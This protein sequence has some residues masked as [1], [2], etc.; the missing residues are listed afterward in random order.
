[1]DIW[2]G[3]DEVMAFRASLRR[4]TDRGCALMTAEYLSNQLGELLRAR[5]I[6]D[7]KAAAAVLDDPNGSLGTFSS[8]IEF[9]YL[10]GLIGPAARRELHLIREVRNDFA[11]DYKPLT[12]DT[13]PIA[14]R[15]HE[16]RAHNLAPDDR[17]RYQFTRS[18]MGL[19]AIIHA[20]ARDVKHADAG[21]DFIS[22]LS[23]EE[24]AAM[25]KDVEAMAEALTQALLAGQIGEE[26][27]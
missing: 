16:L 8:R 19:L 23:P 13:D 10:L 1:L 6:D 17:P 24:L 2:T 25:G 26:D 5:F 9:A 7:A 18:A 27:K 3:L 4:E 11:H 20:G 22:K 14:N 15:C 21:S 12:F